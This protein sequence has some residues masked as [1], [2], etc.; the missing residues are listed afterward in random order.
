M[1]FSLVDMLPKVFQAVPYAQWVEEIVVI[2][3]TLVTLIMVHSSIRSVMNSAQAKNKNL[4]LEADSLS[5]GEQA[6]TRAFSLTSRFSKEDVVPAVSAASRMAIKLDRR[7]NGVVSWMKQDEGYGFISCPDLS[8]YL[9]RDIFVNKSQLEGF[10]V[11]SQ[12]SFRASMC[13]NG[14]LQ[15]KDLTAEAFFA[16]GGETLDRA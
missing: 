4:K 12:V 2:L 10:K 11:G 13:K 15:A 7:F 6:P 5:E 1:V 16:A 3:L 14:R 9:K 8:L